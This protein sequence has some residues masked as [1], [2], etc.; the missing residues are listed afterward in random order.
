MVGG[1]KD[2]FETV[3]PVLN[4]MGKTIELMGKCGAGQNTK[5]LN[6]L[7]VAEMHVYNN[8]IIKIEYN[9]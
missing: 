2:T 1:D 7:V 6:Q 5:A 8:I 3:L 4:V 9:C